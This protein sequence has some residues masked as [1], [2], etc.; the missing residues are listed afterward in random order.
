MGRAR[1]AAL[2]IGLLLHGI[3]ACGSAPAPPA[4]IPE[5][6]RAEFPLGAALA[7]SCSGC[8][9]PAGGTI[10]S[11]EGRP[12]ENIRNALLYYYQDTEGTTVMHR[13][14][15]GYSEADIDAISAYLGEEA[16]P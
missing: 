6:A 5:S 2:V 13:M 10:S 12:A 11:L 1:P 15:R 9:N 4:D 3:T 7:M 16:E 14:I 8:H